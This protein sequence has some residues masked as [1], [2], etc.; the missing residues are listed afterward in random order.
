[1]KLKSIEINVSNLTRY[2]ISI[3]DTLLNQNMALNVVKILGV[4]ISITYHLHLQDTSTVTA[5][6]MNFTRN[7]NCP[8]EDKFPERITAM[9]NKIMY[10][11][12][13][14]ERG[15]KSECVS[16]RGYRCE[17]ENAE[18]EA[19]FQTPNCVD[20]DLFCVPLHKR[21]KFRACGGMTKCKGIPDCNKTIAAALYD[22][23][24]WKERHGTY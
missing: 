11:F 16:H 17:I 8:S 10:F 23:K 4:I 3:Q 19:I 5:I 14:Y 21:E 2:S 1:M 22:M 24:N 13:G 7:C 6:R 15:P 18:K 20:M 9:G 12:C